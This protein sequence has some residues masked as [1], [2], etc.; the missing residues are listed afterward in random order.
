MPFDEYGGINVLRVADVPVP[1]PAQG[2]VLVQVKAAS[3]NPGE[4]KIH[5]RL[6]QCRQRANVKTA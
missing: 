5:V 3:I 1:E 2:E 6:V 4:A